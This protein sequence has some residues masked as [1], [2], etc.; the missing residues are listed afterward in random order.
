MKKHWLL[1]I[2]LIFSTSIVSFGS[3]AY[4][5]TINQRLTPSG[6]TTNQEVITPDNSKVDLAK[7]KDLTNSKSVSSKKGS[8]ATSTQQTQTTATSQT[9]SPTPA[10]QSQ[11]TTL[12]QTSAPTPTTTTT[13]TST[14]TPTPTPE[15]TNTPTPNPVQEKQTV[16]L[17]IQNVGDYKI[18]YGIGDTAWNIMI[19]AQQKYGFIMKYQDYGWGIYVTQLGNQ[20]SQG[21]YYWALYHNGASSMVGITDLKLQPNDTIS[22]KY[23]SWL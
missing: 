23:E 19:R 4:N 18:D 1:I 11:N 15:P 20:P 21:T 22:W 3:A 9:Q 6:S 17:N 16:N 13:P 12:D 7:S 10:T 14:Q 8:S 2:G 5:K